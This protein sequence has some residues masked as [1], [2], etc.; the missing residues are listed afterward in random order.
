MHRRFGGGGGHTVDFFGWDGGY[1]NMELA[2]ILAGYAL[3]VVMVGE[4]VAIKGYCK[5][6]LA[7]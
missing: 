5:N 1:G 6:L 7:G 4:N 2:A 3:I